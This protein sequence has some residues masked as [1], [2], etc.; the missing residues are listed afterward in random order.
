M[1]DIIFEPKVKN[2][3]MPTNSYFYGSFYKL[4]PKPLTSLTNYK[5]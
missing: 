3:L 4:K 5:I 2:M 1:K